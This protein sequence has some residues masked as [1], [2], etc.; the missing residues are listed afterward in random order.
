MLFPSAHRAVLL[1]G[2]KEKDCVMCSDRSSLEEGK[3]AA[4]TARVA[5]LEC[6]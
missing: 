1:S 5:M 2:K 3:E 4:P 6:M